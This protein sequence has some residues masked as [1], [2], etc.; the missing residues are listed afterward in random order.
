VSSDGHP[1]RVT[2]VLL[3]HD[4]G[5]DES[6]RIIRELAHNYEFVR[7]VWLSRNFGQHA[8]TLAGMASSGGD[9]IVTIDEDGQ[10]NPRYMGD[11]LDVAMREHATLVYAEPLNP[12]PHGVMRNTASRGAKWVFGTLLS[13]GAV[14]SFQSYRLVLGEL[15]R[16]I[17]A[18]AGAGV[19]LDVALGWVAGAVGHCP[20]VL[21]E[22]GGRPSGYSLRR[23]LSHFWRLVLTSGTRGLRVVSGTGVVIGLL[24]L[25]MALFVTIAR[26]TNTIPVEG[27]A[28]VIVVVLLGVGAILFSLGMIAEYVGVSVNMA[29]GKPPYLIVGDPADGPLGRSPRAS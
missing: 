2:E 17:A 1:F 5:P 7:P 11:L 20:V 28:S 9:W 8:A 18:Y 22:E 27:W 13:A 19:Y 16:S 23:L 26:I 14:S 29:M 3:V 12:P 10:H 21:R 6:D 24:G 4:N 25:L 15:G